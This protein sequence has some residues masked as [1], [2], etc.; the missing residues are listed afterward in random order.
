MAYVMQR[1]REIHDTL[2]VLLGYD[3]TVAHEIAVKWYEMAVLG[4][5]SAALASFI[6]PANLLWKDPSQLRILNTVYI[7]HV[8]SCIDADS[9]FFMN[10]YFENEFETPI[11]YLR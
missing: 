3:V 5:P 7:P 10:I 4:L 2:H 6:G 1:Y 11:S 9:D 8:M